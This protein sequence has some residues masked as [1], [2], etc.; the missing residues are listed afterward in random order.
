MLS[1]M[2]TAAAADRDR[3]E[4]TTH[5]VSEGS[6]LPRCSAPA[7]WG[8]HT[9]VKYAEY[10][11]VTILHIPNGFAYFLTY[12]LHI[13]HVIL[14]ILCH[15]LHTIACIFLVIFCILFCIFIVIFYILHIILHIY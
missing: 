14:H 12:F 8:L 7:K 6:G 5:L 4:Q 13:M 3:S 15:I 2:I 11:P 10:E 9:Y 1:P